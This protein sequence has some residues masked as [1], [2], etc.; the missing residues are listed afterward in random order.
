MRIEALRHGSPIE[1]GQPITI[2]VD[3][4]P[5]QA[6]AG[7]T[8]ATAMLANGRRALRW[9]RRSGRPRGLFCAM[10]VCFDCLVTVNGQ[11]GVRA[12]LAAVEPGM[13]VTLPTQ[14]TEES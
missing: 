7:E 3:G 12:C 10:G 13:R 6:R 8:I 14:F 2:H 11:P 9:T 5:L 1:R 4:Q